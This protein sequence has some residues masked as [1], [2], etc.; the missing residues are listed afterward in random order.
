MQLGT[1]YTR[2]QY[3]N[4]HMQWLALYEFILCAIGV[5]RYVEIIHAHVTALSVCLL[6]HQRACDNETN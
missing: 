5:C 6:P 4:T 3:V 1:T 2:G